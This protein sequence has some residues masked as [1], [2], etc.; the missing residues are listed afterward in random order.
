ML[1]HAPT[2]VVLGAK[3]PSH[4][5]M[6]CSEYHSEMPSSSVTESMASPMTSLTWSVMASPMSLVIVPMV[7]PRLPKKPPPPV[8]EGCAGLDCVGLEMSS[9]P[10]LDT[11][12]CVVW[13]VVSS[14][15]RARVG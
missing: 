7:S 5:F 11:L 8:E 10:K 6:T 13:S 14:V 12:I 3:S 2:T 4:Q 15:A 1:Y 9:W